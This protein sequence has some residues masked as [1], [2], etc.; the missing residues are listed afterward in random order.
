MIFKTRLIVSL[1]ILTSILPAF[2]MHRTRN[3]VKLTAALLSGRCS[4]QT[5]LPRSNAYCTSKDSEELIFK[6]KEFDTLYKLSEDFYQQS[7]KLLE[8]KSFYY[9]A[10]TVGSILKN[11]NVQTIDEALH[12]LH[13]LRITQ[14]KFNFEALYQ[15]IE[16]IKSKRK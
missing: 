2:C 10:E 5:S 3:N 15:E 11:K 7:A 4:L 6:K 14:L 12:E 16:R 13:M 8:I 9:S 1:T